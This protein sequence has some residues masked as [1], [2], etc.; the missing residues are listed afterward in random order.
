MSAAIENETVLVE[1][2]FVSLDFKRWSWGLRLLSNGSHRV[3]RSVHRRSN[4]L[5]LYLST[6][7][8]SDC[9]AARNTDRPH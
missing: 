5:P 3:V 1:E 2:A 8:P 4:K 7:L 6:H 9:I